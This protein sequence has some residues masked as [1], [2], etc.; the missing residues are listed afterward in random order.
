MIDITVDDTKRIVEIDMKEFPL[1][2]QDDILKL[3]KKVIEDTKFS[4]ES[5]SLW[6]AVGTEKILINVW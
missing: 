1:V 3:I 5:I 6:Q 2:N 4:G